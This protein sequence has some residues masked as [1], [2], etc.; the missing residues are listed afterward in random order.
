MNHVFVYGTLMEGYWNHT[1]I[2]TSEQIGKGETQEHFMLTT[3]SIPFVSDLQKV[4]TIKGE[5]YC[6]DQSTMRQLDLLEGHPTFYERKKTMVNVNGEEYEAW[7]Y[8][9]NDSAGTLVQDGDWRRYN[10]ELNLN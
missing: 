3:S 9:C 4:S 10:K 8:I 1:L 2:A 7:M 5:L 6:V